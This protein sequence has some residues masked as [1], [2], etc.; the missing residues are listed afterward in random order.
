MHPLGIHAALPFARPCSVLPH[1][2]STNCGQLRSYPATQRNRIVCIYAKG[3]DRRVVVEHLLPENHLPVAV[4]AEQFLYDGLQPREVVVLQLRDVR[5][6]F[7]LHERANF[8]ISCPEN[9]ALQ[10]SLL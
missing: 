4:V 1:F 8:G 10:I 3:T 5:K 9:F 7:L 2:A 6:P